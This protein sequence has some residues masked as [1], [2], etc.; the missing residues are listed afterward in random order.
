MA[1][2]IGIKRFLTVIFMLFF[3]LAGNAF[4]QS[5]DAINQGSASQSGIQVIGIGNPV[6]QSPQSQPVANPQPT[7]QQIEKLSPEQR[8][9]IESELGKTGGVLTPEAIEQLKSQPEFKGL[10]PED[11][12]QGKELIEKKKEPERKELP[13]VIEKTVISTEGRKSLFDRYRVV[14]KYQNVS[15]ELMPFGYEFFTGATVK[16]LTQRQDIPVPSDHVVG[17]GDEVKILLWGRV[18]A[19]YNLVI[20]RD[21]NITIPQ[22]GPLTVAGMRFGTMKNYL[23]EQAEQ[24]VGANIN[25]TMGALKSISIFVLGE[26]RKPGSYTIGSLS[27]ITDA[28]ILAG[29]PTEIGSLRNIQLKRKDKTIAVLDFYDL[30][31]KGDKSQDKVLQ[32][33]DVIFVPTSG[34]LVGIAGNVK[35]PAIYELKDRFDLMSFFDIAGGIVPTAYTQQIQ[36]ERIQKNERQVFVDIND[37]DLTKAKDFML[38]DADL[39]KVFSIVDKDVNAV[40]LYGNLKRPGK[41]EY[42]LGMKVKDLIK[43]SDELL[44]ETHFEYALVKRLN[45]PGLETQL[46]PFNL[47]KVLLNDDDTNNIELKPQDS[48]YVFSKWL[49]KDKPLVT[50]E[51]EVRKSGRFNLAENTRVKD[52]ILLTGGLTKDAYLQKGEIIRLNEKREV[53]RI[54]FD[55]GLAMAEDPKENILL[56]DEDRIFVRKIPDWRKERLVSINGEVNFPGKYIITRGEKLSSLIERA[57][58]FT[59]KAYRKGALFTRESIMTLQQKMLDE[60]VDKL[61]KDMFIR[62]GEEVAVALTPEDAKI[63]QEDLKR[64]KEFITKLRS[65]KAKGRMVIHLASLEKFRESKLDIELE[66]GDALFIPERPG[67]V[68]VIGAVYNQTAFLYDPEVSISR[69][70]SMSGGPTENADKKRIYILKVDGSAMPPDEIS[71][72]GIHWSDKDYRWEVADYSKTGLDPGD[73]IV[74][75]EKMEKVAWLKEVKDITQIIFQIAVTA[76]VLIVLF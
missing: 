30:L 75:P 49:F 25:V 37:K 76:G 60:Y 16:V 43:D 24:I 2:R 68:N 41:Y 11:I 70:I 50:V 65:I 31:L 19:Q 14:E 21:G 35:R 18:N 13:K 4:A 46:I 36:V 66:D 64:K 38:Q 69:Y 9:A 29:G 71:G 48:I 5:P 33:G 1:I 8:K 34:P 62:G 17:P 44:P 72:W 47:G 26:A 32:A 7:Q 54:Y 63:K 15:T 52:A 40:Y 61:E 22:V 74:V 73:T 23:M 6:Q 56:Q 10:T 53:S 59:D 42:K 51:G 12:L 55:V 20:D 45:P 3:I 67:S 27:T 28:L 39:V 57:G 58:G